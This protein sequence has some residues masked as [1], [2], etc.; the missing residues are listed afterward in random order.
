MKD[1]EVIIPPFVQDYI[2]KVDG[3]GLKDFA[4]ISAEYQKEKEDYPGKYA[5][6]SAHLRDHN[7]RTGHNKTLNYE[8]GM[9]DI[10]TRYTQRAYQTAKQHGYT[11]PDPHQPSD[12][13]F[14]KQGEKFQGMID[15]AQQQTKQPEQ[16]QE[17][18]PSHEKKNIEA[19]KEQQS[20]KQNAAKVEFKGEDQQSQEQKR[21][22]FLEQIKQTRDQQTQRQHDQQ[23]EI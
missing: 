15:H 16:K 8:N 13:E 4:K 5:E 17:D 12:K 7:R 19:L 1:R 18:A 9:K 10:E 20:Y 22:A 23:P 2:D 14:T 3:N 21:A 11:G 6:Q